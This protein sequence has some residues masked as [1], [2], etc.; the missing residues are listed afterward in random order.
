[1]PGTCGLYQVA[2][3]TSESRPLMV[4]PNCWGIAGRD[5]ECTGD[6]PGLGAHLGHV[7]LQLRGRGPVDVGVDALGARLCSFWASDSRAAELVSSTV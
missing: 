7:R 1:M 6:D 3:K 2:V 4:L 5:P